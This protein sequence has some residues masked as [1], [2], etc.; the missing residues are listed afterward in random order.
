VIGLIDGFNPCNM[1]VLTCMLTLLVATS[2]S[3]L[4]VSLVALSFIGTSFIFYFLFMTA[5]F[6]VFN[7]IGFI[8][9]LRIGVAV[10]GIIAGVINFK[11]L[12]FFKQGV[13]LMIPEGQTKK[14]M[15]RVGKMR[16]LIQTGSIPALLAASVVLATLASLVELPCTAGLPIIFTSILSSRGFAHGQSAGYYWYIG[17]YC[18]A[19]S[20]PL[21]TIWLFF[22]CTFRAHRLTQRHAEIIKFIA[23]FIMIILGILLLVNPSL[24]GISK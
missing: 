16:A 7:Y 15:D 6:N 13:S 1:F 3:K 2:D 24:V 18:L 20:I 17:Y 12:L 23:G 11:E 10:V 22:A 8:D 5:W 21:V 9:P 19:Y 4:R 14:L